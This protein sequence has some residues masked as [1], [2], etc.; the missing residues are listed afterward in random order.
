M[1]RLTLP[2]LHPAIPYD[3][4]SANTEAFFL[5][6]LQRRSDRGHVVNAGRSRTAT[7]A[8]EAT[9]RSFFNPRGGASERF[10]NLVVVLDDQAHTDE[11]SDLVEGDLAWSLYSADET[12]WVYIG[13]AIDHLEGLHVGLG[14]TVLHAVHGAALA[15][16]GVMN[17]PVAQEMSGMLYWDE[18]RTDN[19]AMMAMADRGYDTDSEDDRPLLPSELTAAAGGKH[20]VKPA[21]R[22]SGNAL[23]K[24]FG[25]LDTAL[26]RRLATLVGIHLPRAS[27]ACTSVRRMAGGMGSYMNYAVGIWH[28]E[29]GAAHAQRLVDD[30]NNDR[31]NSGGSDVLYCCETHPRLQRQASKSARSAT[32]T[33]DGLAVLAHHLWVCHYLDQTLGALVDLQNSLPQGA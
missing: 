27:K 13:A 24:A 7:A 16:D 9:L 26:G 8:M 29:S 32:R 19:E 1:D 20:W 23:R 33:G 4:A 14:E 30:C 17:A 28:S 5:G 22:L 11:G 10:F 3:I 12:R 25:G 31:M 15:V 2:Q 21:R 18:G 6:E